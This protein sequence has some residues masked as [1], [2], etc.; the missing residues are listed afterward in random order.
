[1]GL[2]GVPPAPFP[3]TTHAFRSGCPREVRW[4]QG[5]RK[6]RLVGQFGA[7]RRGQRVDTVAGPGIKA[8]GKVSGPSKRTTAAISRIQAQEGI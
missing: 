5:L 8:S 2:P 4:V 6:L 7:H 3:L 1:M